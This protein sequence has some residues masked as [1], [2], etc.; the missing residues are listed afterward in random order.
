MALNAAGEI[1]KHDTA[2]VAVIR[3]ATS[4]KDAVAP[5]PSLTVRQVIAG[6]SMTKSTKSGILGV[7]LDGITKYADI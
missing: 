7:A 4:V 3:M 1:K 5:D 2:D 6:V